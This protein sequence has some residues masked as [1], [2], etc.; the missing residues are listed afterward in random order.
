MPSF[1]VQTDQELFFIGANRM[2]LMD[3]AAGALL[4]E[5]VKT[6]GWAVSIERDS[7]LNQTFATRSEAGQYLIQNGTDPAGGGKSTFHPNFDDYTD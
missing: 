3:L 4:G 6:T 2:Q 7:T 5:A 1:H